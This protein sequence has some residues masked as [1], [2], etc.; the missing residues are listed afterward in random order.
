MSS[1]HSSI[2][3]RLTKARSRWQQA[4][5]GSPDISHCSLPYLSGWA[6]PT[7]EGSSFQTLISAISFF[8]SLPKC[9][10]MADYSTARHEKNSSQRRSAGTTPSSCARFS[11]YPAKE[12]TFQVPGTSLWCQATA[13]LGP[14]FCLPPSW[15]FTD[16][17]VYPFGWWAHRKLAPCSSSELCQD[18]APDLHSQVWLQ[19]RAPVFLCGAKCCRSFLADSCEG[20]V[21]SALSGTSPGTNLPWETLP[22]TIALDTISPRVTRTPPP[23]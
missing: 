21:N 1:V 11:S 15:Q 5:Q 10:R 2:F 13:R 23:R 3:C 8:R 12:V 9:P 20:S 7:Y 6:Q 19:E 18:R 16:P 4:K 22:A 17:N 14:C